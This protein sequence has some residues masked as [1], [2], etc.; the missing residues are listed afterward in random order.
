MEVSSFHVETS[1]LILSRSACMAAFKLS[2]I[3]DS[4]M[5]FIVT[6]KILSDCDTASIN[7]NDATSA[8]TKVKP[9]WPKG[10][11]ASEEDDLI[12]LWLLAATTIIF[13]SYFSRG[14]AIASDAARAEKC[15]SVA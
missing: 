13:I 6:P 5:A 8:S 7:K 10:A 15:L 2:R 4:P 1:F 3:L 9:T 11:E 12:C 14:V